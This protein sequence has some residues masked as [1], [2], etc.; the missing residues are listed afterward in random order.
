[1]C[2]ECYS[3]YH[4][5]ENLSFFANPSEHRY[6]LG[7]DPQT[8]LQSGERRQIKVQVDVTFLL[9]L[10]NAYSGTLQLSMFWV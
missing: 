3:P 4:F 7:Y 1:M 8:T 9:L 5:T 10:L 2:C 6:G